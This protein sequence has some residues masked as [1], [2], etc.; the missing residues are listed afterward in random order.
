MFHRRGGLTDDRGAE[1]GLLGLSQDGSLLSVIMVGVGVW[2][3]MSIKQLRTDHQRM[4]GVLG[5]LSADVADLRAD[6]AGLR[7]EVAF[8]R[9]KAEQSGWPNQSG[10]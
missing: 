8:I 9:G 1:A 4:E 5:N 6:I 3:I 10:E 2:A 7:A